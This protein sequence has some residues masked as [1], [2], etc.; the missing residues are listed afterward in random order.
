MVPMSMGKEEVCLSLPTAKLG[1]H[2][3]LPQHPYPGPGIKDQQFVIHLHGNAGRVSPKRSEDFMGQ[4]LHEG[5]Y[6]PS[7]AK[8]SSSAF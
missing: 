1:G 4:T 8:Y 2:Q 6:E 7:V 5:F 3:F